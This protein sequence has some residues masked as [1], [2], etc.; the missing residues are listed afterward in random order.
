MNMWQFLIVVALLAWI[1]R[2]LP[3]PW[4]TDMYMRRIFDQLNAIEAH[5]RG[6][7]VE[8]IE[9]ELSK[10]IEQSTAIHDGTPFFLRRWR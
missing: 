1:I 9:M 3:T 8:D 5:T 7:P 10:H 2:R 4:V 6:V